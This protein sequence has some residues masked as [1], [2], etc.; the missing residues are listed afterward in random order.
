MWVPLG[1]DFF[2]VFPT[3]L[4]NQFIPFEN[5]INDH[6]WPNFH[7]EFFQYVPDKLFGHNR[8]QIPELRVLIYQ[9]IEKRNK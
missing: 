5:E 1:R 7:V 2:I 3:S 8:N 9:L 6:L 4:G